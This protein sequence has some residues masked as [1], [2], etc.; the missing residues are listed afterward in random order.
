MDLASILLLGVGLAMDAFAVSVTNGLVVKRLRFRFAL[1]MALCFGIAQAIMPLIGYTLGYRLASHIRIVSHFIS[2]GILAFLGIKMIIET[3][4]DR[5]DDECCSPEPDTRT[6]L[7]M[8]IAT[9]IDALAAGVSLAFAPRNPH[10]LT[11]FSAILII[12]L[13]TMGLCM[14]GAYLGRLCGC[15]IKKGA[16]I[17]GGAVLVA[18]GIKMLF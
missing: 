16:G 13:I 9:S 14:V 15:K 18:I 3:I 5:S 4:K 2:F 1:K 8:A 10:S 17:L 12:G 6:I 11:I 7:L